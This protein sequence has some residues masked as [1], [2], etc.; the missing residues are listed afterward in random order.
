MSEIKSTPKE[1]RN[2][3]ILFSILFLVFSAYSAYKG[4][5]TW[6]WYLGGSAFFLA[7]GLFGHQLLRPLYIG[8][9]KFASILGWLN[10]RIILGL[11]FFLIFTPV[12]LIRRLFQKDVLALKFDRKAPSY[13]IK[14][15]V[16]T[17]EK[18][19]YEQLF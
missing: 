4:A 13:W 12:G 5:P 7:T 1:L 8:W 6:R 2:F 14:R 17:F 10:T 9:M 19:R 15:D 3:G 16:T 11:V 18:K